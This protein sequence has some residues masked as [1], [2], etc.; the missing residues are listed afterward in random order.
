MSTEKNNPF[1]SPQS[2]GGKAAAGK[3]GA[4]KAGSAI[5]LMGLALLV[6]GAIAFWVAPWLPPNGGPSGRLPSVYLLGA[7]V[8]VALAGMAVRD[9]RVGKKK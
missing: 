5:L 6:Y 9:L 2:V 1:D 4:W 8:V 7:G 3:S